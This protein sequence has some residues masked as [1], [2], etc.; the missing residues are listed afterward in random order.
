VIQSPTFRRWPEFKTVVWKMSTVNTGS[1]NQS[2]SIGTTLGT[3]CSGWWILLHR[4]DSKSERQLMWI[5]SMSIRSDFSQPGLDV[6]KRESA[7][8][9]FGSRQLSSNAYV[10]PRKTKSSWEK[11][12]DWEG[13]LSNTCEIRSRVIPALENGNRTAGWPPASWRA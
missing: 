13:R 9:T 1:I 4:D 3:I 12:H 2:Q 5:E 7:T 11:L 6:M 8:I 10:I